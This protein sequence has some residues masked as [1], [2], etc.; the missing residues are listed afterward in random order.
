MGRMEEEMGVFHCLKLNIYE[1]LNNK[2][3]FKCVDDLGNF[4]FPPRSRKGDW[5]FCTSEINHCRR[6]ECPSVFGGRDD[7]DFPSAALLGWEP[8]A[9]PGREDAD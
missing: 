4:F 1:V 9:L 3:K 5:S 7:T 2:E 8:C 6:T